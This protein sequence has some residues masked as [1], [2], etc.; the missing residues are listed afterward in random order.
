MDKQ[1]FRRLQGLV[2]LV[3]DATAGAAAAI[4]T[5]HTDTARTPYAVL[6]AVPVVGAAASRIGQV[7]FGITRLVYR[8][9]RAITRGSAGAAGRALRAAERRAAD[10]E[11]A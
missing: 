2:L 11:D 8:S 3:R 10:Q 6:A 1:D 5:A 9:V 7:Q 4:E